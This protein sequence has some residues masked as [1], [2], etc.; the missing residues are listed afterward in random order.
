MNFELE[1]SERSLSQK[2]VCLMVLFAC[3][4][5]EGRTVVMEN[6]AVMVRAI[7]T[8][9]EQKNLGVM[10]LSCILIAVMVT[11]LY[12]FPSNS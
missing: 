9:T 12:A 7:Y 8:G 10:G 1:L 3:Y 6:K 5:G 11:E 2:A 4:S